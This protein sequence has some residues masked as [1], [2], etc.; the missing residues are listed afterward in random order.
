MN[1]MKD[2]LNNKEKT[3]I[4]TNFN[5]AKKVVNIKSRINS[6]K[7]K[8][9]NNNRIL[10][11]VSYGNDPNFQKYMLHLDNM[12]KKERE[13]YLEYIRQKNK[14]DPLLSKLDVNKKISFS[15]FYDKFKVNS[16][17]INYFDYYEIQKINKKKTAELIKKIKNQ[18]KNK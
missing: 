2:D 17:L 3:R 5:T 4:F 10:N 6:D 9:K 13:E 12:R 7:L 11:T 16:Y 15:D 18:I 8:I 14:K 1:N